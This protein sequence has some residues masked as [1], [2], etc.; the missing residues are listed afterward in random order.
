[1]K[2]YLIVLALCTTGQ[3]QSCTQP[4]SD[5]ATLIEYSRLVECVRAKASL[6]EATKPGAQCTGAP[7][8]P[9]AE[10]RG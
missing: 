6:P 1:M 4:S 5:Q 9:W 7:F 3:P 8:D 10:A 2:I